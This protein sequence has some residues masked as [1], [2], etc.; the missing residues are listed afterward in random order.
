MSNTYRSGHGSDQSLTEAILVRRPKRYGRKIFLAFLVLALL[1]SVAVLARVL[2][3]RFPVFS[4]QSKVSGDWVTLRGVFNVRIAPE[5]NADNTLSNIFNAGMDFAVIS[6]DGDVDLHDLAANAPLATIPSQELNTPRGCFV[7]MGMKRKIQAHETE[8]GDTFS[9]LRKAGGWSVIVRA[10]GGEDRWKAWD[11]LVPDAFEFLNAAQSS[12]SIGT[13]GLIARFAG[14]LLGS[15]VGLDFLGVRPKA[16]LAHWDDYLRKGRVF[17]L[18]GIDSSSSHKSPLTFVLVKDGLGPYGANEVQNAIFAG[19]FY[20]AIPIY[21]DCSGFRFMARPLGGGTTSG[22]MGD[23]VKLGTGLELWA[24]L[25]LRHDTKSMT[26]FVLYHDGQEILRKAGGRLSYQAKSPGVYRVEVVV[27]S[28][29]LLFSDEDR[30]F[31]YSN[32]IFVEE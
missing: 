21:G 8:A 32:P 6:S 22:I 17:G 26:S 24:G 31:I 14:S 19:H 20:C 30:V 10:F 27:K 18:C 29:G 2:T 15:P 11:E 4:Q 3:M 28:S 25:N 7:T 16:A 12:D 1:L 9:R 13:P 23:R 5:E